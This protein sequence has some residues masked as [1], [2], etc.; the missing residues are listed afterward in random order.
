[1]PM[2]HIHFT[3]HTNKLRRRVCRAIAEAENQESLPFIVFR[4][5]ESLRVK[6]GSSKLLNPF[7]DRNIGLTHH[8]ANRYNNLIKVLCFLTLNIQYPFTKFFINCN[9]FH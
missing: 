2:R 3:R 7:N 6:G 8:A 1:M 4:S 5:F 9:P